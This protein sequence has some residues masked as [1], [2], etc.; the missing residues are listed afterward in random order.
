[1]NAATRE[2]V[3]SFF[4]RFGRLIVQPYR[5]DTFD[6]GDDA[7]YEEL[8]ACFR[9]GSKL[10][11]TSG[12]HHFIFINKVLVGLFGIMNQLKPKLNTA[13][14]RTALCESVQDLPTTS[15]SR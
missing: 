4:Q 7:F 11:E 13:R 14:S 6:F 9:E 15:A 1:M 2:R 12:S 8:K 10:R 3:A 5:S